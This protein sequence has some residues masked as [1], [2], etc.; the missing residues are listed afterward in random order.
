MRRRLSVFDCSSCSLRWLMVP[1]DWGQSIYHA[2]PAAFSSVELLS[3]IAPPDAQAAASFGFRLFDSLAAV[4]SGA[5][6]LGTIDLPCASG[7]VFQCRAIVPNS[8]ARRAS[9]GVFRFSTVRLARCGGLWFRSIGDNRS[10][11][12]PTGTIQALARRS[13]RADRL[14]CGQ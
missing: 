4:A 2:L 1:I 12:R 10:I 3:P 11:I 8:S 6:R 9:G 5:D 14:P 13:F 7:E